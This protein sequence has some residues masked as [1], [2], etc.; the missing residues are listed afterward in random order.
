MT[1]TNRSTDPGIADSRWSWLYKTSATAA[2][3][4]GILF[5]IAVADL[6]IASPGHGTLQAWMSP[7]QNNWLV[8]IFK[9]HAGVGG[10]HIDKLQ[11]FNFLD[12]A[13]LAL[14]ATVHIG[15]YAVL[16]KTSK[17]WSIIAVIQPFLGM[18]L[19][20]ATKSAGRSAVMGAGLVIS[21]VML[22]SN[23]FNK[24][25]ADVGLLASILLLAGDLSAGVIPPSGLI[26][27]LF[28]I[29]YVLLMAWLFLIARRL[30]QVEARE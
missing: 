26:A 30:L 28:G 13:I 18:A 4:A 12:L 7:F 3:L 23:A 10:I 1:A 8:V 6:I 5:L 25:I 20:I 27:T 22:R 11:I 19:F 21:A 17:I 14:V 24:V 16:R 29:G 2:L 15:L 9:L